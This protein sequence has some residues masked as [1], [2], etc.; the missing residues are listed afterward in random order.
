MGGGTRQYGC[1][2]RSDRDND[3]AC[4]SAAQSRPTVPSAAERPVLFRTVHEVN[5]S[6]ASHASHANYDSHGREPERPIA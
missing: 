5:A 1:Q 2:I 4:R 3:M 6:H